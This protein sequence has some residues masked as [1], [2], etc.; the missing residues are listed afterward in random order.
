MSTASKWFVSNDEY[1]VSTEDYAVVGIS[2]V[3]FKNRFNDDPLLP[4]FD[5]YFDPGTDEPK[6][7]SMI[8]DPLLYQPRLVYADVDRNE[9][10][11]QQTVKKV[12]E[13]G[14]YEEGSE[15]ITKPKKKLC[16][17]IIA[18]QERRRSE[19]TEQ[20]EGAD[21]ED[22]KDRVADLE[23][24]IDESNCFT[25]TMLDY[26][27]QLETAEEMEKALLILSRQGRREFARP[28]ML[29]MGMIDKFSEGVKEGWLVGYNFH[30]DRLIIKPYHAKDGTQHPLTEN[31]DTELPDDGV[32]WKG[33]PAEFVTDKLLPLQE[34]I[35][36][37]K[38]SELEEGNKDE[39]YGFKLLT[40]YPV[41]VWMTYHFTALA[42]K[43][44]P[45]GT[46]SLQDIGLT[47]INDAWAD[48][49]DEMFNVPLSYKPQEKEGASA[50][51]AAAAAG[52]MPTLKYMQTVL[53]DS[54]ADLRLD[55]L[56]AMKA[57]KEEAAQNAAKLYG[58]LLDQLR[59][60][61]LDPEKPL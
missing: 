32:S 1:L 37:N 58:Q 3:S 45:D 35:N 29:L 42:S 6:L 57:G 24:T 44:Q 43:K 33:H 9:G 18:Y 52:S 39:A 41:M 61:T 4:D 50:A 28:V 14:F 20:Y 17:D 30:T 11:H 22:I 51:A 60:F 46:K 26:V 12:L 23:Q 7:A 25:Q 34:E 36:K 27:L 49:L 55:A 15:T 2:A 13:A 19:H 48:V 16:E 53:E 21:D 38:K 54:E 56:D 31:W 59:S 5:N 8:N 10:S 47:K 40:Y